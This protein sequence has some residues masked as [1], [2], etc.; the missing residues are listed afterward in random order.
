MDPVEPNPA[1]ASP[2]G[3]EFTVNVAYSPVARQVDE[4]RVVVPPGATVEDAL[5]LCGLLARHPEIVLGAGRVGVWGRLQA[6]DTALRPGD[7][8]EVYRPL[9]VDPMESR[10]QRERQQAAKRATCSPRK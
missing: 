6:L 3:P 7:R 8:V 9:Q 5:R 2:G 1:A 10:R 4:T